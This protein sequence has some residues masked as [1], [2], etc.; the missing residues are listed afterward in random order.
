MKVM[1][2]LLRFG[3]VLTITM[4]A[5]AVSVKANYL[6]INN[7]TYNQSNGT[8]TFQLAWN[9]SWRLDG[10]MAPFNW[11]AAWIFAKWRACGAPASDPWIHGKIDVTSVLN[12]APTLNPHAEGFPGGY[13]PDSAGVM[14]RRST[15]GLFPA[16][17]A[18]NV[19]I[20]FANFPTTGNY[21][22]RVFGI[23]MVYVPQGDY[24]L[25]NSSTE[26]NRFHASNSPIFIT[27]EAAQTIT[28]SAF[29][30]N[31]SVA[32]GATY[33]KGYK[34]FYMM[35]Y[36]ISQGQY[37]EFLNTLP[38]LAQS[39]RF[40]GNYNNSRNRLNSNGALPDIYWSDREDRAQNYLSWQDIAAYLDWSALR[41]FTEMEF[42]KASRGQGPAIPNEYCWG[43][44]NITAITN[45][46]TPENG[47]ETSLTPLAN[48]NYG[49]NFLT[50][51]DGGNGPIRVGIFATAVTTTREQTGASYYGI[52]ELSG[53]MIEQC[54]NVSDQT[55]GVCASPFNG[56]AGDGY[57]SAAGLANVATWPSVTTGNGRGMRGGAWNFGNTDAY[58][59]TRTYAFTYNV[60]RFDYYGGRGAR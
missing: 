35:K 18:T 33:P 52:M 11:D 22:V 58:H 29:G 4:A 12:T 42:E 59:A 19:T 7:V 60:S 53:N 16:A 17:A 45:I 38:S 15:T 43:S 21:D 25:G 46:S 36:E 48:C 13:Y 30:P 10:S 5:F 44:G 54:V 3:M 32:L 41:P 37:A 51:G 56:S 14:L 9:N 40:P 55:C 34:A 50:G 28:C 47:T 1:K 20:D 31:A 24:L 6:R 57:L 8:V 27:S 23:E 2:T 26:T 49:F 39:N